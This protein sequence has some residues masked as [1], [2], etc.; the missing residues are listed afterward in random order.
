MIPTMMVMSLLAFTIIQL[1][2]GDFITSY[3]AALASSGDIVDQSRLEVLRARYGLDQ[4]FLVQYLNWITNALHGDFGESFE[5]RMPV[6][7]LIWG[8]MAYTTLVSVASL[9]FIW[10]VSFPVGIYSAVRKYSVGDYVATMLCFVGMA[11]P[12]FLKALLLMYFSAVVLGMSVGGLFSPDYADVPWSVARVL[13]LLTHLWIPVV[14]LGIAGTAALIR[15]MRAN[16]LDELHKPYVTTARAKG[17]SESRL[18]L[19]YP[20][21]VAL[22]PF[23]ST[24]GWVLP[25]LISGELI[26]STVLSL[27]TAGPLLLQALKS[28][29]MYLAGAFIL[30]MCAL[31]LIGTLIS[32][33]LLAWLDP[34]IRL[35]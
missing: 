12:N 6:S 27:P 32:D 9:A 18:V 1:P 23:I 28:Q 14:V 33:L 34:R 7:E 15:V 30:L 3:A 10:L 26:V 21:R 24:V 22:N 8:R 16:L 2:P 19:R 4:P 20:V 17:V 29:D 35:E 13:D 25:T 11:T 5:W 31:V